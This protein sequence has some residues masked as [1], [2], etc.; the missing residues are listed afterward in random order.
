MEKYQQQIFIARGKNICSHITYI[1][2]KKSQ[3]YTKIF[4]YVMK[5]T[6]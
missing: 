3:K 5:V 2:I 4:D 1:H 6:V